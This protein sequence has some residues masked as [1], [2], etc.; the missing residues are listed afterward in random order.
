MTTPTPGSIETVA[1]PALGAKRAVAMLAGVLLVS[2]GA[3]AAVPMPGNP[4]PITLQVPAVLI[5]GGLLGPALGSAT[6]VLYLLMGAAGLPVFAPTGTT[7]GLARLFGPTGGY[8][9]AYPVAAG[10]VGQLT[11]GGRSWP[12]LWIGLVA[13]LV[14]IHAGGVAQL[15]VMGGDLSVALR[16]GSLPFLLGDCLKVLLAGLVI[17][18]LGTKARDLL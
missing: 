2:L 15:A 13:G 3:Q 7:F 1:Q 14:V 6:L 17:R 11:A 16:L 4:V 5:V 12:R 10:L 9:L 18:R 8:L